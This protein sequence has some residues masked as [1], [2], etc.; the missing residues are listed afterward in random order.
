[1]PVDETAVTR[2]SY[3]KMI[4]NIFYEVESSPFILLNLES[5]GMDYVLSESCYKETTLQMN[6]KKMTILLSLSYHSFVKFYGKK[7]FWV[8]L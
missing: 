3:S 5:T 8:A 1:M 4:N 2:S 7:Y 6:F